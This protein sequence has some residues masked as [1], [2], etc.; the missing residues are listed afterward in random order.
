[1]SI[2]EKLIL[3]NPFSRVP[4]ESRDLWV[5]YYLLGKK[6]LKREFGNNK[7]YIF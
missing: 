3:K 1:M 5:Q 6:V 4:S 2:H 7:K